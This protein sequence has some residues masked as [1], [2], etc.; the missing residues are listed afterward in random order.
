MILEVFRDEFYGWGYIEFSKLDRHIRRALR[1]TLMAKGIYMGKSSGPVNQRLANLVID[2]QLP[3]WDESELLKYKSMYPMSK[4]WILLELRHSHP[5]QQITPSIEVNINPID[6]RRQHIF[7]PEPPKII[8][9]P[10]NA[11]GSTP[12]TK[13]LLAQIPPVQAPPISA[14]PIQVPTAQVLPIQ[15]SLAQVLP[16]SA[17][18]IQAPL[19]VL[20]ATSSLAEHG[21]GQPEMHPEQV[22]IMLDKLDTFTNKHANA[23]LSASGQK[24]I[25]KLL[26][27]DIFKVVTPDKVVMPEEV[28]S[29]TQVF[30]SSI[31]D[32]GGSRLT[33]S[34]A[35]Y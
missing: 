18:T 32:P 6:D 9:D 17:T 5:S 27:K 4:A 31:T 28:P 33:Y 19:S 1:K 12:S 25:Q 21:H 2:E 14:H 23:Q 29:N 3:V 10:A 35:P 15:V 16:I 11:F 24:K 8:P 13:A 22:K 30:N 7:T 34:G 26:E 20:L